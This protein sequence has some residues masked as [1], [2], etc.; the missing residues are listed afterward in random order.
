M[1]KDIFKDNFMYDFFTD[2]AREKMREE[3]REKQRQTLLTIVKV[4]FPTLST[5]A[6]TQVGQI[7]DVTTFEKV[8]AGVGSALTLE[9]AQ[10]A[11]LN[12]QQTDSADK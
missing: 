6:A 1:W 12:W 11:L 8:I 7:K 10:H 4:R 9:N 2:H 5:L 3:V